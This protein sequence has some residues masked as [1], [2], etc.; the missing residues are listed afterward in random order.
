MGKGESVR[1]VFRGYLGGGECVVACVVAIYESPVV[2][3]CLCGA[4]RVSWAG[5]CLR[6]RV[7]LLSWE[8]GIRC[9]VCCS[10]IR[11]SGWGNLCVWCCVD[12]LGSG[13]LFARCFVDAQGEGNFV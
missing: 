7:P 11:K 9:S 8:W 6:R 5:G 2:G 1:A 10:Y 3:I 4:A 13:N 12:I